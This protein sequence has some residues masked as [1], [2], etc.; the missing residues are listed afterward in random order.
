MALIVFSWWQRALMLS[1]A[2]FLF[3]F[4]VLAQAQL[5][6]ETT[7]GRSELAL[8]S[9][10]EIVSLFNGTNLDGWV[11]RGGKARYEVKDDEI[12]GTATAKGGGN[13]FLCTEKEYGDFILELEIKADKE[14]NSGVQIRSHCFETETTYAFGN[15]T[16]KIPANRVHGY[17][18]E[19]DNR[20]D[21][22]WS[23][24]LYEESRRGWLFSL[25]T[26]S[27]AGQAFQ[28]GEWNKYRIQCVGSSIKTWIND[29]PATDL[30][31]AESLRGFIGLQ[32]HSTDKAGLQVRFRNI[33][34]R[35]LGQH[36]WATA[37]DCRSFDG[38][39]QRGPAAWKLEDGVLHAT[40]TE[41]A[42]T[43][44]MLLGTTPLLDSAVRFKY[45]IIKTGFSLNFLSELEGGQDQTGFNF[46]FLERMG[47]TNVAKARD[48]NTVIVAVQPTRLVVILNGHQ[49]SDA[50]IA[51]S[52]GVFPGLRLP[53][54]PAAEVHFKDFE[55]LNC[56]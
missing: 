16:L 24:G 13:T 30:V 19:V 41:S 55:I 42:L 31:D 25:P 1:G 5:N 21:R 54:G 46:S 43:N 20:P 49:L 51:R 18:V 3:S 28:F 7:P 36:H 9:Q 40:Q 10:R 39:E 37:W 48:W 50:S 29:V 45:K 23:G 22:R 11:V 47:P 17:Q 8:I 33:R 14:L 44:S 26:N 4:T 32:V 34:L 2:T 27:L 12:I 6:H 53:V 15:Q 52:S 35:D 56:P 38:M